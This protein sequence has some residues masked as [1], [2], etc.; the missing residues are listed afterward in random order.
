M[1]GRLSSEESFRVVLNR[2]KAHLVYHY[3][4]L[5]QS[6]YRPSHPP[7]LHLPKGSTATSGALL[8]PNNGF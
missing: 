7:E 2:C 1:T 6:L 5:G 8:H 3:Q 4:P